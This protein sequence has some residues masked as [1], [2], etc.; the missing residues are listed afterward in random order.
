MPE[1][2]RFTQKLPDHCVNR[3]GGIG[4]RGFRTGEF[5]GGFAVALAEGG[6]EMERLIFDPG[7]D[8]DGGMAIAIQ[9][10]DDGSLGVDRGAG[11]GIV[12]LG[13]NLAGI[14]IV[15]SALQGERALAG[16]GQHFFQGQRVHERWV[17]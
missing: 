10:G 16:S 11:R 9:G 13:E 6:A 5:D 12:Q 17:E 7:M 2:F 4:R 3:V 1:L 15:L 8:G 14:G